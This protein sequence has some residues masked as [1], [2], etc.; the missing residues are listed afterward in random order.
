MILV[1]GLGVAGDETVSAVGEIHE[2]VL[3][4]EMISVGSARSAIHSESA[5][6]GAVGLENSGFCGI[7]EIWGENRAI[8]LAAERGVLQAEHHF[9]AFVEISGHPIGA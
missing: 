1:I 8:N 4:A 3:H 5:H 7:G 9:D 6:V 2:M